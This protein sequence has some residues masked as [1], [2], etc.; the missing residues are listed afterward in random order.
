MK[1]ALIP[2][3]LCLTALSASSGTFAAELSNDNRIIRGSFGIQG[4]LSQADAKWQISFP[5]RTQAGQ[6][7]RI[8]SE[9]TYEKIDSPMTF[10][11]GGMGIGPFFSFD[12]LIGSGSIR[13]GRSTDTD[14][15]V[16]NGGGGLEFSQSASDVDGDV[17]LGEINFY[18]NNH[19]LTG[20]RSSPWGAVFGYSHYQDELRVTNGVQIV[21]VNFDGT[22]FPP[23][24]PFPPTQVLNSTFNFYWNAIK[25]GILPQ[26][27][28]TNRLTVSGMFAVYPFVSYRGEGYWNLRTGNNP[29][30]FRSQSPNF[31]Q[32]STTGHGYEATLGL[33]YHAS[34]VIELSAG[35][36]YFYLYASN[37]IDTVYFADGSSAQSNLDWATV[38]RHGMYAEL[39]YRF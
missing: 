31:I 39:M 23:P 36:R 14:R 8:E 38:T 30:D 17:T 16:Q 22:S 9:L 2:A 25:L 7:G 15:F 24:G 19:R 21:S 5:Y 6:T 33:R 37:G 18:Y 29:S 1:K 27:E 11:T 34:E 28:V 20:R 4:W 3:L 32:E 26:F 35:Y 10:L 13:G 12:G